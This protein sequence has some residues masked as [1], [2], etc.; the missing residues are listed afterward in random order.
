[1]SSNLILQQLIHHVDASPSQDTLQVIFNWSA[2]KLQEQRASTFAPSSSIV[3][4]PPIGFTYNQPPTNLQPVQSQQA[5][6]SFSSAPAPAH[7][8]SPSSTLASQGPSYTQAPPP[9][10]GSAANT[11]AANSLF[12]NG[13]FGVDS[14]PL[15]SV[16]ENEISGETSP[17]SKSAQLFPPPSFPPGFS[18]GRRTSVSAESL[19]PSSSKSAKNSFGASPSGSHEAS[20]KLPVYP[21][22]AQQI[23]RIRLS[24]S[25]NFLFR[26]LDDEQERDVLNAMREI[27]IPKGE[28]IIKQGDVGDYFYVVEEGSLDVFK[29]TGDF[30]GDDLGNKVFTSIPGTSFGELALMYNAPRAASIVATTPCTL[31]ALD[32]V[33]FRTI[34]LDHTSSKRK[35]YESF[36]GS[37]PI[38]TG[39][40]PYERAKIADALETK[41]YDDGQDVIREGEVGEE[42]FIIES[43]RAK[44]TKLVDGK[45][46]TLAEY[47]KGDYFG[48]LAL[49]N[50]APRAATVRAVGGK[51][52]L[53]ALGEKAFTRLLGP[54]KDI[55]ARKAGERYGFK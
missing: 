52:K 16:S 9:R 28:K 8:S 2:A 33:T 7:P 25:N 49:I 21:K 6:N 32:R 18:A 47:G 40:E 20:E 27:K 36:L 1:M 26:N 4:G 22:G 42:F 23:A 38:L 46:V 30:D 37:I 15:S 11:A 31:W 10:R 13:P 19:M 45:E 51:L 5:T 12:Q 54:T 39:L 14:T 34:L 35:M 55:M 43:G 24:I 53:A 29:K 44:F 50:R 41:T 48:E 17:S 3:R